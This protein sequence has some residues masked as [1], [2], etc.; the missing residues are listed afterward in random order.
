[1][2]NNIPKIETSDLIDLNV[3]NEISSYVRT[4]LARYLGL[5]K[6]E[7]EDIIFTNGA[8][9]AIH[10]ISQAYF[11]DTHIAHLD[12]NYRYATKLIAKKSSTSTEIKTVWDFEKGERSPK[13][14]PNDAD[15]LYITNPDNRFGL[16]INREDVQNIVL[17]TTRLG[18][19]CVID[20][21]YMDY[22]P[23]QSLLKFDLFNTIIIRTF[24]KFF[25]LE[26]YRIG[27]V[28]GNEQII[29]DLKNFIPQYPI[30]TSSIMKLVES[31]STNEGELQRRRKECI[32]IKEKFYLF[33]RARKIPYTRSHTNFVTVLTDPREVKDIKFNRHSIKE[34]ILASTRY[35][36]V[37]PDKIEYLDNI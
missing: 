33:C 2:N 27:Y 22:V 32:D 36:R 9:A 34:F 3:D 11:Q 26:S 37:S 13:K 10:A 5:K 17:E 14:I 16:L 23:N 19:I 21:S 15:V 20:E 7:V 30:A 1:M 8:D 18:T 24:A 35:F 28:I 29:R 12:L 4:N 6:L 31:I 25:S